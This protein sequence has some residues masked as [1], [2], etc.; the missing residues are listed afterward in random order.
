MMRFIVENDF[1]F[2]NVLKNKRF[3]LLADSKGSSD[4]RH[5]LEVVY[6]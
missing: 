6:K 1:H 4:G 2:H 5:I 3:L